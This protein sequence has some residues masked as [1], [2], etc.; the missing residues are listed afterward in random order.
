M[1][2]SEMFTI[3]KSIVHLVLCEFGFVVNV[4]FQSRSLWLEQKDLVEVMR[5]FKKLYDML[6]IHGAINVMHIHI[7]KP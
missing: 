6:S 4:V 5:G 7:Q 3:N 2:F 1:H